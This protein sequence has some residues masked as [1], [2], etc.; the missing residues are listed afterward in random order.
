MREQL[1]NTAVRLRWQPFQ[2]VF[3][4]RVDVMAVE[5][6]RVD[7]VHDGCSSSTSTQATGE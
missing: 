1:A 7:Q 6:V 4:I 2:N 3:Q 5:R